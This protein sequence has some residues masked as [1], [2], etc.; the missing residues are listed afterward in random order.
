[1][2]K[3]LLLYA[4]NPPRA[5]EEIVRLDGRVTQH[6][7]PNILLANFHDDFDERMLDLS[8]TT[9]P[10]GLP[11]NS[12]IAVDA[13]LLR[14]NR[15]PSNKEI[16][17]DGLAWNT[18][19]YDSPEIDDGA[20]ITAADAARLKVS[21]DVLL[22]QVAVGLVIVSCSGGLDFT[23]D[24]I[25]KVVGQTAEGTHFLAGLEPAANVSFVY[26]QYYVTNPG[27]K[28][29]PSTSITNGPSAVNYNN[30]L[31]GFHKGGASN[32]ELCYNV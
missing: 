20:L 17:T 29:V 12:R 8:T 25:K 15:T 1:M 11:Y 10:A 24:E 7:A 31:Y 22:G 14:V 4:S 2:T 5:V 13:W 21:N 3:T 26:D 27:D 9:I 28:Q 6:L 18:P 16:E 23:D 32:G 30:K 19:G